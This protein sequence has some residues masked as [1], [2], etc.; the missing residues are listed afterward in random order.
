VL[1]EGDAMTCLIHSI[2]LLAM[3]NVG[4]VKADLTLQVH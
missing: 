1:S 4:T 2:A 3:A